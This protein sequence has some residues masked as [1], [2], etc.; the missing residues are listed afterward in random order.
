[1]STTSIITVNFH[2]EAVTIAL[3]QSIDKYYNGKDVEVIIV[4]NGAEQNQEYIFQPHFE[5][6]KYIQSREN[7]GF[8]G[9]N[10]LGI[11]QACGDY[12][13]LLNND[14]ELPAGCIETLC[15]EF[16]QNENIG[17]LSPLLLYFDRKDVIQYAGFTLV[18]QLT[19]RNAT[20]GELDQNEGQYANKS[21]QTGYCHGAAMMCRKADLLQA[22]L[23]DEG[24]FLY[25]EE[26]DWCEKFKRIG[27]QVWFTGKTHVYHK[28]SI[29]VGIDSPLKIYFHTRNRMLFIRK[30]TGLINTIL[31]SI[32][33]TFIACPKAVFKFILNHQS[34]L[35]KWV[36]KGLL[37]NYVH[38]KNSKTL[39]F[40]LQK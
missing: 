10:N 22:G 31:F 36:I 37:W 32:Y 14:T 18:N 27:K 38:H 25:Y 1:M 24:Y 34:H 6:I 17:L 15:A 26:L 29:S 19:G 30:N 39:G 12:I 21:Y 16:E 5:N 11:K 4:D 28:E 33:Y 9:G 35:A 8:A 2:Q 7:L 23:M 13:F 3:L 40:N 20:I